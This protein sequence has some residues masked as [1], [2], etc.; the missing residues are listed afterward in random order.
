M[1]LLVTTDFSTNSKG[2]IRYSLMLAKQKKEID[3]IFYHAIVLMKPTVWNDVFF[4]QYRKEEVARLTKKLEKFVDGVCGTE[5]V[6]FRSK[7]CVVDATSTVDE[8]ILNYAIK[9]KIE[10]ISMATKGAGFLRKIMGTNTSYIVKR[11]PIPVLVVPSHFRGRKLQQVTYLSDFE[12]LKKELNRLLPFI[13][14]SVSN[15][16]VLHYPS[17]LS[18]QKKLQ[19]NKALIDSATPIPVTLNIV[20]KRLDQTLIKRVENYVSQKKPDL[21]VLFTKR[22]KSFFEQ[23]FLPSKSAELTYTTRVPVLILSK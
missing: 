1:K 22:E 16:E 14:G 8:A 10:C 21:L 19:K 5:S 23:L 2:A 4:E 6:N 12:N 18:D 20:E 17:V 13:P 9:N 15:L 11:S 3:V 7:T